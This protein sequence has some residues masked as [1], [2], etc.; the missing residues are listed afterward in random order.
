MSRAMMVFK[1]ISSFLIHQPANHLPHHFLAD[2]SIHIVQHTLT[3]LFHVEHPHFN[4]IQLN[5][6]SIMY[7]A[8]GSGVK[9]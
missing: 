6:T 5:L 8:S 4:S 9:G 3:N 7:L 2:L 1:L